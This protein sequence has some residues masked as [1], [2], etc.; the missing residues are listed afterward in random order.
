MSSACVSLWLL[1]VVC[2]MSSLSAPLFVSYYYALSS[3]S[4]S[5]LEFR[6]PSVYSH[7]DMACEWENGESCYSWERSLTADFLASGQTHVLFGNDT[8][9]SLFR[10]STISMASI[11]EINNGNYQEC[12]LQWRRR[13]LALD[14]PRSQVLIRCDIIGVSF[15]AQSQ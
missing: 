7:S 1:S 10:R 15:Q 8:D 12:L 14:I 5:T 6:N 3:F 4:F 9:L 13:I 2:E 11:S